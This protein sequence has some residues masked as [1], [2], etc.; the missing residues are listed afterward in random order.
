[1][2]WQI[3]KKKVYDLE[4]FEPFQTEYQ[5]S[6]KKKL[7]LIHSTIVETL[8]TTFDIFK[9]DGPVVYGYWVKYIELIDQKIEQA[10][11]LSVKRS[12]LEISRAING[13]SKNREGGG[14]IHPL[15]KVNVVLDSQ[16][17]E[18]SPNF[19]TL[20][21]SVNKISRNMIGVMT[22][23]DR[24]AEILTP[25]HNTATSRF[26]DIISSEEEVL[27]LFVNIKNGMNHNA[28]KCTAYLR[29]WDSYREIWEI[30]KDAFIR[31]YA[32]LKPALST[33]DADINRYSE[34]AN[35]AQKEETLTYI[36]FVCLDCSPLKHS[37]VSHCHAWQ[38]KL[39]TLLNQNAITELNSLIDMFE[40]NGAKL[41]APPKDLDQLSESLSLLNRLQG[42]ISAIESQFSPISE[43]YA[44]LDNYEVQVKAEEK[45]K[46]K[47][48]PIEW[49]KFQET[50]VIAEKQL[51]E[52]KIKFKADLV[53]SSEEF[54]RAVTNMKDDFYYKGPF[55]SSV[56]VDKAFKAIADYQ[57]MLSNVASQELTL[58]KGLS[59]FKIEQV[60]SKDMEMVT[61]D[62]ENLNNIWTTVQDWQSLYSKWRTIHFLSLDA[63]EIE[64][65]TQKFNKRISKMNKEVKEW[66]VYIKLKDKIQQTKRTI[67]L[68]VDLRNPAMRERHWNSIMDEIG[69]TFSI[70][71]SSFTMDK[72]FELGLDQQTEVISTLSA[73]ATKEL[74]IE[75]GLETISNAWETL[76]IEIGP[77]REE[78]GYFKIKST[79]SIFELLED[80]QVTLSTMKASK[81]FKAFEHLVD[82]WER[83]LSLIVE[84]IEVLLQVQKQWMYLESI[85]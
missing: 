81:F 47:N 10:L 17:I 64:E 31:R 80:N 72:I 34:I 46:L 76:D 24:L 83:N 16:K 85:F 78:K 71:E 58:K 15:F 57:K 9:N 28:T 75:Q 40:A 26:Y 59:V 79:D 29:N 3:E 68:L 84:V 7:A 37:I 5:N 18:F 19:V 77:Y 48:L 49:I 30:N 50:L 53:T 69:K 62:V 13:E 1:M 38:N 4:N 42:E 56:P 55:N 66:D 22:V 51:N 60:P 63:N 6:A 35:N 20:E 2:L 11:R 41:K 44:I 27:K 45:E 43:M 21:A 14:E 25:E 52:S 54:K 39:T 82:Q 74:S 33:F 32:K 67:P 36:N 73:A 23:I 8:R 70:N 61:T 12:L 65:T